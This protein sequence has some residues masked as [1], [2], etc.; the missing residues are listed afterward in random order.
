MSE[1]TCKVCGWPAQQHGGQD[2]GGWHDFEP[3]HEEPLYVNVPAPTV[4]AQ[5]HVRSVDRPATAQDDAALDAVATELVVLVKIA[6]DRVVNA[7]RRF[8]DETTAAERAWKARAEAAEADAALAWRRVTEL[9]ERGTELVLAHRRESQLLRHER[10]LANAAVSGYAESARYWER[11]L[12]SLV[13]RLQDM[14][15]DADN[16]A[17]TAS[18]MLDQLD[19][20]TREFHDHDW[21][22]EPLDTEV[23]AP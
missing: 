17:L 23:T 20:L 4:T 2:I 13:R 11:R 16:R 5:A 7:L 8:R 19:E 3:A 6:P 21:D 14:A 18:A 12:R 9:Q 10:D 22:G 15:N 1:P